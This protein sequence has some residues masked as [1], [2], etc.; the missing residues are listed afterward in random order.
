MGYNYVMNDKIILEKVNENYFHVDSTLSVIEEISER[1]RFTSDKAKF[2]S[3]R[4]KYKSWDGSIRL[5]NKKTHLLYS[6]LY[7]S[8]LDFASQ[9]NYEIIG[10][11][12]SNI[13]FT[14]PEALEFIKTLNLPPHIEIRDYQIKYFIH[15]IRNG[16]CFEISPTGSGKSLLLYFIYRYLNV[17]TLI[18]VPTVALVT[19]MINDFKS[20]GYSLEKVQG[21]WNGGHDYDPKNQLIVSTEDTV[22]GKGQEFY[23][24]FKLVIGDEAHLW[25]AD[26]FKKIYS[27][28]DH[29]KNLIGV[30]GS[31]DGARVNIMQ[32]EAY[33]G[34]PIQFKKTIDLINDG[35]LTKPII[36]CII[37][38]HQSQKFKNYDPSKPKEKQVPN[39]AFI[40][41]QNAIIESQE[42]LNNLIKLISWI[43]GTTMVLFKNTKYGYQLFQE[44]EK[45]GI[46]SFFVD[47]DTKEKD[48]TFALEY[49]RNNKCV[50]F[51]TYQLFS[52]GINIP[53][54]TDI[55]FAQPLKSMYKI[56]QSIG[57]VIRTYENKNQA[58]VWDI[59]DDFQTKNIS[60]KHFMERVKI[61]NREKFEYK[62][63]KRDIK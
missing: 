55:I 63:Y 21:L 35:V 34:K 10:R 45:L 28:L 56:V 60:I 8:L 48:R 31:L 18:I 9:N 3:K 12:K 51:A 1:F 49:A 39:F 17:K 40:A 41:E 43:N 4:P 26:T 16:R 19:Q 62:I 38:K 25:T 29:V 6:G 15:A 50:I 47:K 61:Y 14:E 32:I 44:A 5:F 7:C 11:F 13:K 52:T 46:K 20:Y 23:D 22:V 33:F 27:H 24:D 42:R 53:R 57:R 59:V 30:T 58:I 37:F 36:K 2:I 54:L